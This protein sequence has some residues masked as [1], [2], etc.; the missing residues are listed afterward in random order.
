MSIDPTKTYR[1]NVADSIDDAEL[2][3]ERLVTTIHDD[4]DEALAKVVDDTGRIII[5]LAASIA[6][7]LMAIAERLPASTPSRM[8]SR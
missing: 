5:N 8:G 6:C 4:D 1:G 3:L 2:A 7:A